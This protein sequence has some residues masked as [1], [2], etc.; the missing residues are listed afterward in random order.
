MYGRHCTCVYYRVSTALIV[1]E[2]QN[3]LPLINALCVELEQGKQT[4]KQ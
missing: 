2:H 3:I 4:T 1:K